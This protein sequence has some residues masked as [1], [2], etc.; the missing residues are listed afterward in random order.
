M[1]LMRLLMV[2]RC[3]R[4]MGLDHRHGH[5]VEDP[6]GVRVLGVRQFLVAGEIAVAD[7]NL[8]VY[9]AT[10]CSFEVDPIVA[11]SLD[12][13]ANRG[14]GSFL[15]GD[16]LYVEGFLVTDVELGA[17]PVDHVLD[18]ALL[19]RRP[20]TL[21]PPAGPELHFAAGT[22]RLALILN[23]RL[24]DLGLTDLLHQFGDAALLNKLR[25]HEFREGDELLDLIGIAEETRQE[26]KALHESCKPVDKVLAI[27]G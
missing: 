4:Q 24:D 26:V 16:L 1:S 22:T 2:S 9:L 18:G 23:G 5:N 25:A 7:L 19:R 14:I 17:N 6:A 8:P 3:G 13:A 15:L 27:L 12:G 11:M 21:L 10:V 20:H